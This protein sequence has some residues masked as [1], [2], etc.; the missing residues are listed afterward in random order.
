MYDNSLEAVKEQLSR[1]PSKYNNS[2][3]SISPIGQA[4]FEH[5]TG[6]LTA[7]LNMLEPHYFKLDNYKSYPAIKVEMLERNE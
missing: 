3:L 7:L 1:D 5:K 6:D 2:K 4:I